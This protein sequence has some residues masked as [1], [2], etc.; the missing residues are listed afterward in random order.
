MR[1]R[2]EAARR[3]TNAALFNAFFEGASRVGKLHPRARPERHGVEVEQ[4][5]AYLPGSAHPDHRLDV[6]RPT[7]AHAAG[8]LPI[9]LYIHGGGFRILSKDTHW[10]MALAF[11]RRGYLVFNVGYRLAPAHR[12]P[13]AIEDVAAAFRWVVQNA[14][15]KGGDLSR[16]VIAGE[17]AG[18]NLATS[19]TL[20]TV[21]DRPEPFARAVFE[22]GVTP[23][24]SLPACGIFQV[25]DVARFAR[26]KSRFPRYL[27]DQLEGVERA[28]LGREVAS[29]GTSIDFADVVSW[30]ER[31]EQP[32][33]PLPPFFLPV[34]T[35]DPL[36]DDTR[37][38]AT[39]LRALGGTA[40]DRYYPGEVHAFHAFPFLP[41]ARRC[42]QHKFAFLDE[43]A[44]PRTRPGREADDPERSAV[45]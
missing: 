9:V 39:A 38:L 12:F 15:A 6:Y 29:Y 37:R 11:A 4:N 5:I 24:A 44:A 7:G 13:A 33:R 23:I 34:G 35:K 20:A 14:E 30:L 32:D 8:S 26:R 41:N 1:R 21:Y 45:G 10:A 28:Y 2:V 36:L 42:W 31:G 3:R 27:S 40:E 22:S 19:L 17:S 25:S 16:L 43:H 18:A